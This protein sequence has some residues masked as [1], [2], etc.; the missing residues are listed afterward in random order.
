M[1]RNKTDALFFAATVQIG[2]R[3]N[4]VRSSAMGR[5]INHDGWQFPQGGVYPSETILEA[6][7]RELNEELGLSQAHV[8]LTGS[9]KDWLK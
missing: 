9:T 5:H 2:I 4:T 6:V 8:K 1:L 3:P 7:Y